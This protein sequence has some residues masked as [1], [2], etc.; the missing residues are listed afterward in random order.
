MWCKLQVCIALCR[1]FC[2]E[3]SFLWLGSDIDCQP[4][5][6]RSFTCWCAACEF[7]RFCS[8][9]RHLPEL[10]LYTNRN[11]TERNSAYCDNSIR[12]D[13]VEHPAP[14]Q[15]VRKPQKTSVYMHGCG[16]GKPRVTVSLPRGSIY[17]TIM[18]L[19]PERPSSSGF[20]GTELHHL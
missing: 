11:L 2:P 18:E 9:C 7:D 8:F 3:N 19:G 17:T 20:W 16:P 12:P 5:L 14:T 1:G 4:Y 13:E 6:I 10:D 15:Q